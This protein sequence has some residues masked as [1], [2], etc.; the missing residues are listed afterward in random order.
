MEKISEDKLNSLIDDESQAHV[1]YKQLGL[2]NLSKDEGRHHDF[3]LKLRKKWYG[4]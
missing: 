1:E 4:Y 3:L 2:N